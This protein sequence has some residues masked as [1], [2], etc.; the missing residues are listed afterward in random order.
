MTSLEFEHDIRVSTKFAEGVFNG[1]KLSAMYLAT[2]GIYYAKDEALA[3]ATSF[4][5]QYLKTSCKALFFFPLLNAAIYGQRQYVLTRRDEIMARLH[6]IHPVFR[7]RRAI[8]DL[9]IYFLIFAPV[10]FGINYIVSGRYLRGA[11]SITL[12]L[13]LIVR[14]FD[15]ANS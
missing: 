13:S 14:L 8:T 7:K 9:T 11:F 6:S 1:L 5:W 15:Q 4:R 10:G 12:M 2:F 3:T